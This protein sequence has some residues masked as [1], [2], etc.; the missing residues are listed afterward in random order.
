[1]ARNG[2][3]LLSFTMPFMINN[4][5]A[6]QPATW[7][8]WVCVCV[9]CCAHAG[10]VPIEIVDFPNLDVQSTEKH[11]SVDC[12]SSSL[13]AERSCVAQFSFL[14]CYFFWFLGGFFKLPLTQIPCTVFAQHKIF[15]LFALL[16]LTDVRACAFSANLCNFEIPLKW[17]A[18]DVY[19]E[20]RMICTNAWHEWWNS[21]YT[22]H[23]HPIYLGVLLPFIPTT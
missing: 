3:I 7:A 6:S 4:T 19:N 13:Y 5:W 2:T 17:F 18:N 15:S 22:T 8:E 14:F 9:C 12:Q 1:M 21:T 11:R 23:T 16:P 10:R 20:S